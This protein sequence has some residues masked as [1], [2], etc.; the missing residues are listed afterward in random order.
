[1]M[2]GNKMD[3]DIYEDLEKLFKKIDKIL[4]KYIGKRCPDFNLACPQCRFN[5]IYEKFKVDLANELE[6]KK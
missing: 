3:S 6:S 4:E 1:M 2:T 5:L